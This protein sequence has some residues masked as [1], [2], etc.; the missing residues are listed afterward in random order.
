M[1][2]VAYY[3]VSTA[4][5]GRSGLGLDAQKAGIL[6]YCGSDLVGEFI[7][8]ESG[9][10]TKRKELYKA[11]ELCKQ[12]GAKLISYRLDRIL[13]NLEILVALRISKVEFTALDC[14]NDSEMIIQ[15]KGALAED[16]LR[17]VSERTKAALAQKKA[18]G[19]KL[20]KPD[21]FSDLGRTKGTE[22][23]KEKAQAN[24]NNQRAKAYAKSLRLQCLSYLRIAEELNK[25]GFLSSTGKQFYATGIHRLLR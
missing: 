25:S 8:V 3:R 1:K 13:R 12:E 17:K 9:G 16:E 22:A 21:N 11:I 23:I 10:K 18:Q 20:G 5:Q 19:F 7:E 4:K 6:T 24:T 14:L 2:Y 15:I